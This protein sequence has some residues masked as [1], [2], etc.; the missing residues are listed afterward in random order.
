MIPICGVSQLGWAKL[1]IS[2]DGTILPSSGKDGFL[3]NSDTSD[4]VG[5]YAFSFGFEGYCNL[6]FLNG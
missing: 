3:P 1:P 5:D 6:S 2:K 4:G